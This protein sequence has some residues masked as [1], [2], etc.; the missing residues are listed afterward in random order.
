MRIFAA[1]NHRRSLAA[2]AIA[3][4]LILA[5]AVSAIPAFAADPS[6][7]GVVED[8]SSTPQA[9][10]TVNVID[11]STDVTVTSTTTAGDG[12]FAVSVGAGTYNVQFIP[13]STAGLQSFLATGVSTDSAPLT[14]ILKTATVVQVQGTLGD[15][16][17]NV[18]PGSQDASVTFSSPLNPGNPAKPDGSG[19]YAVSL[20]AD[21][22]FTASAIM[23]TPGLATEMGFS[24]LPVGTLDHDQTYNL[25]VPTARLTVSVR[26]ASGNP[27]TGGTL[28]FGFSS[29]SPLPGLPGTSAFTV[30]DSGARLDSNG[31]TAIPVPAGITLTSPRIVLSNGLIIPF[32]LHPITG[33]RHAFIIFNETTGS[34]L[35]DD[36]PP[37]VT[38]SPDRAPNANGWYNAPVTITWTSVDP[39]PSSGTPTTPS[40]TTVSSEGANQTVT[41]GKSCDPAGNCATG[42]VTGISLDMTPPSVSLTSV[43]DGATYTGGVAPTPACS[44]SDSLSG[45]ATSATLSV[46]NS[47]NTYTATCSGAT[48]NAGNSTPPV[49][50]TYQVLPVGWTTASLTDSGGNPI[51]GASVT[52]RSASGSVTNATT[53]SDGTAGVALAPGTY[54]ATMNYATGYQTKTITVTADGPNSVSFA[55]VAVTA[56]INDPDT[57]D[58]ATASISH[59][60]NTGTFGP[61]TA[62]DNSGQVT[63][64]VLPGTNT[65]TAYDANGYQSQTINVTGPTTVS[66]ATVTVTV[67]IND[68]NNADLATASVTHAGNT[69]TFG[70]KTTVDNSGQVT[71][72]VL[73]GTSTFTAY[74]ANGYQSHTISVT[75]P[76]N[77]GFTTLAVTVTVTKNGSPLTTASVSHAGN[78][79][80]FGPKTAVDGNGQVTFQVLPG[81]STFTAW[82]GTAYQTQT[83]T[84]TAA[85]NT[86]ISVP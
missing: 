79:G 17:G 45:V 73:P 37:V 82:D 40:P 41:S 78:T 64:Q 54:S 39:A 24:G 29:I 52:F 26:D 51:A 20:F 38:G 44:T 10:V 55:T 84:V 22:N 61:K 1:A 47:G 74:D 25:T 36:Q 65:F 72:Q 71:F 16:Q 48:D 5:G 23:L 27:I 4:G 62:V 8:T 19:H 56:Q 50:A 46:T 15:S 6:I 77:V 58:L 63:F 28:L 12:T 59:A 66:F 80:T 18:Y 21:Q 68:P 75:G 35:V 14:V 42:S 76:A 86:T 57:A 85:T 34:V 83:I 32:S 69:G 31:N 2:A 3:L 30:S 7:S 11:P 67:Q 33:D 43:T 70:P 81:T 9:N 49:K 53:G 13:P 60:G